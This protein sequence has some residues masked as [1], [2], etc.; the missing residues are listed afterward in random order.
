LVEHERFAAGEDGVGAVKGEDFLGDVV[1]GEIRALGVPGGVGGIAP[2]A[3]EVAAG[4]AEEDGG[5]AGEFTF[6]LD[7]V[8]YFSD[9]H[10]GSVGWAEGMINGEMWLGGVW[11]LE[12]LGV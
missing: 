10:E 8:E 7:G 2:G 5:Y 4:G 11:E 1:E 9:A 12:G 3:A 6:A